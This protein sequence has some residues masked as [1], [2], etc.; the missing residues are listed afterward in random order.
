VFRRRRAAL[1][2]E[3]RSELE[4]GPTW[5]YAWKL[6]DGRTTPVHRPFLVSLSEASAAQIEAPVREALAAAG[7]NPSAIDIACNE[8]WFAHRMLEW[9]AERVVASDARE[10][11]VRRAALIRDHY[12]IAA[13]RL[14]LIHS[15]LFDL[16]PAR[17][18]SFDVVALLGVIYHLENPMGAMRLA[19]ALTGSL[20]VIQSQVTRFASPIALGYADGELREAPASFAVHRESEEETSLSSL[21]AM[22]GVLSLIPNR[23]AIVEMALAAGFASADVLEFPKRHGELDTVVVLA[24]A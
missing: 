5:T 3:L 22:P 11:N 1:S 10:L 14:E 6:R 17:L 20:C 8:G 12:G 24:R 19:R 23:R 2:D 7:P 15:D 18:G 4:N 13:E 16:D 9:G 21:A